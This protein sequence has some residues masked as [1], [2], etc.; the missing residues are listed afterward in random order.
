LTPA[1]GEERRALGVGIVCYVVWGV[2]PLVFQAM[3]R[4]GAGAWEI[5]AHRALWSVFWAGGL[6]LLARQTPDVLAV[7]RRPRTLAL[8]AASTAFVAVNWA[9][10]VWAVNNGRTLDTS[11]GYYINPLLNMAAGVAFFRERIDRI[12]VAAIAA[13][14]VG[15]VLQGFALGHL[16]WISLAIAFSFATYG[17]IRK[18][19][20]V[21]AQAGLFVECLYLLLPGIAF[22]VWLHGRGDGHFFDDPSAAF[23]L[24][25]AGPM[26]VLPLAMFAWAARRMPLSTMGFLQ[27]FAP[28]MSFVIGVSQGETFNALRAASFGFIWLGAGIYAWGAWRKLRRARADEAPCEPVAPSE[29]G[30]VDDGVRSRAARA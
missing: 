10:F 3:G 27:F 18:Y 6:V 11:L 13:A 28:T 4:E 5:M 15:V 14:V 21:D 1:G 12:G 29:P 2:A 23:W 30:L 16:P 9:L 7:F 22:L 26:T 25:M 19:V 20:S 8:L 24:A 17:I